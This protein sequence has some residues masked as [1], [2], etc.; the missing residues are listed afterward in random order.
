MAILLDPPVNDRDHVEGAPDAALT[1]VEFADYEC[2][3]CGRVYGV[4][5]ALQQ[6]L[7]PRLRVVFRNFPL[8][9]SHAHAVLA[10]EAAEAAGA[11]GR[12]WPMHDQLFE[13]QDAL[14]FSDVV[15]YAADLGLDLRQFEEDVRTHRFLARVR[16]DLRSGAHSGV[17]GTPTLFLNGRRHQGGSDFD[18]L[19]GALTGAAETAR[20]V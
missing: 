15:H 8:P 14:D 12:F 6:V 7:G 11:Q 3:F 18:S 17:D 4:I 5:K 16:A 2:P 13:H 9:S 10:A 1:L 19:W 20:L